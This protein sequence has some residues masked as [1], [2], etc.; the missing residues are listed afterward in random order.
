VKHHILKFLAT[1][2]ASSALAA[3]GASVGEQASLAQDQMRFPRS[4]IVAP[5]L[6]RSGAAHPSSAEQS[7]E[8]VQKNIKV[9]T[10]MPES[11]LI[12]T[13]E[14]FE[15][16]LSVR[17]NYCHVNES[18][19]DPASDA[20]PAKTTARAMIKMVLYANQNTFRGEPSVSCYTCHRGRTAPRAIPDLP[21]PQPASGTSIGANTSGQAAQT[22]PSPPAALPSADDVFNRFIAAL[23]GQQAIDNLKSRESK[24][25][26]TAANGATAQFELYQS[27]PDKFYQIVTSP[28]AT[29]ERGFN[30]AVG[31]QKTARGVIQLTGQLSAD[32]ADFRAANGLFNLIKLREQFSSVRV[33]ARDK[34]EDREVYVLSGQTTDG[35]RERL[36]F[37]TETALLLRRIT[38]LPTMIGLIPR[39]IDVSDYRSV[40]GIKF[41]FSWRL[42]SIDFEAPGSAR[43]FTEIKLNVP[44]DESKFN[45]PLK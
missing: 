25:T 23:G 36:F 5:L 27:A 41:P 45:M 10:G 11:Q 43:K 22:S 18:G 24:G 30:G 9:L 32:L 33:T 26:I 35:N 28:Q 21:L 2:A 34:I 3:V 19:W 38:Y 14:F 15:T 31:W 1:A 44:I 20:K 13:M 16:S 12:P 17:C 40:D 8:Q 6:S 29:A 42:S 37:D 39:Q 7:V 4:T